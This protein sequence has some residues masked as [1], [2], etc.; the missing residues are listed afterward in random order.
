MVAGFDVT[1]FLHVL[2]DRSVQ[3][4]DVSAAGLLLADPRGSFA[5]SRNRSAPSSPPS[6]HRRSG[7][8]VSGR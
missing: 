5:W 8:R 7:G 3:L 1:D 4:L 6:L 2:T